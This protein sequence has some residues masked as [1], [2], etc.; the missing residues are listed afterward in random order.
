[1]GGRQALAARQ[2]LAETL[3]GDLPEH[4]LLSAARSVV[5][6]L[7]SPDRLLELI[8]ELASGE[9]DPHGCARLSYRHVLGFDKLLLI[10][11]GPHHM[12]RAHLWHPGRGAIGKED[13]H[14]HRSPLASK[15]V[16]GRLAMELYAPRGD[17]GVEADRYLESLADGS[18][19]WLLEPTGPARLQL[20]QVAEYAAG[21]TYALPAHTLHRAWCDTAEPTVTL[22]LETGNGR[23]QHT[24]V[25]TAA[26]PHP[27]AVPKVPMDVD[28]YLGELDALAK[29]LRSS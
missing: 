9:G 21:S 24:D 2:L 4:E 5:A 23:R 1:M 6:E 26:G 20:T 18:A 22:F 27:G 8:A 15:V 29:L 14:N 17:G 25:F 16:R 7:G 11:D 13:I 19:D 3:H 10:D 12:L 28:D